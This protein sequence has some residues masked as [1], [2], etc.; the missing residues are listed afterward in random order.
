MKISDSEKAVLE[1]IIL[2]KAGHF[3]S[4]SCR[5]RETNNIVMFPFSEFDL[6]V[7]ALTES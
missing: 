3:Q 6:T 1:N 7:K 4:Q 5:V 2:S